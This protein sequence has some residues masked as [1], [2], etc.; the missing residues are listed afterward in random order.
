MEFIG[1]ALGHRSND[2]THSFTVLCAVIVGNNSK[3]P[4]GINPQIQTG[5]AAR[6]IRLPLAPIDLNTVLVIF[7]R[8][9]ALSTDTEFRLPTLRI[10]TGMVKSDDATLQEDQ[11]VK[12]APVQRE[13]Q[14]RLLFD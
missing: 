14:D 9:P 1:A 7:V 13:I 6:H 2:A 8:L 11:L 10:T 5:C 3:F 4:D 12:A